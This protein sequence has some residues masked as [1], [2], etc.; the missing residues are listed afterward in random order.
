MTQFLV[1]TVAQDISIPSD[2]DKPDGDR[3]TVQC[4][5]LNEVMVRIP[6]GK[7][8]SVNGDDINITPDKIIGR[9]TFNHKIVEISEDSI[10][11]DYKPN[12]Y[13]YDGS[14]WSVNPNYAKLMAVPSSE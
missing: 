4:P 3:E 2:V 12:S 10:P 14:S 1:S 13:L 6:D 8:A 5:A 7:T 11:A 9:G